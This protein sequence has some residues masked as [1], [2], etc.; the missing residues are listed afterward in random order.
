MSQELSGCGKMCVG[1]GWGEAVW[2]VLSRE[3]GRGMVHMVVYLRDGSA[4]TNVHAATLKE[5]LQIRLFIPPSHSI[6]TQGQ[7]VPELTL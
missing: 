5:K 1:V 4:L 7:P 2:C 3:R 6:L